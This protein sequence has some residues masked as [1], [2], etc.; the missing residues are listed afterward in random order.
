MRIK[1][2]KSKNSIS[3]SIIKDIN[4]KDQLGL[5]HL[6]EKIYDS[7]IFQAYYFSCNINEPFE[8]KRLPKIDNENI[9]YLDIS[10][11]YR[12]DKYSEKNSKR[13]GNLSKLSDI[14]SIVSYPYYIKINK[15]ADSSK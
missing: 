6:L 14:L 5:Y 8:E 10:D 7:D 3:Y 13:K 15:S 9:L 11:K 4:V 1:A 12:I 2:S